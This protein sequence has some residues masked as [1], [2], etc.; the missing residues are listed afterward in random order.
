MLVSDLVEL[1]FAPPEDGVTADAI[2]NNIYSWTVRMKKFRPSWSV[3]LAVAFFYVL[4]FL[5]FNILFVCFS[6]LAADLA[7]LKQNFGYDYI[8][9]RVCRQ[10]C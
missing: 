9:L 5:L 7:D 2:D 3:A 6:A 10:I 1:Y 4:F 8:E